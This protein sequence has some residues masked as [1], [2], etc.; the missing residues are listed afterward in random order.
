[1]L[2]GLDL[3]DWKSLRH[4]Y[5]SAEN[6]PNYLRNLLSPEPEKRNAAYEHLYGAVNHQGHISDSTAAVVPFLIELLESEST[7]ERSR[8]LNVLRSFVESCNEHLYM[9]VDFYETGASLGHLRD[10]MDTYNNVAQ[11]LNLFLS[12][13][14]SSDKEVR[15]SAVE[16]LGLLPDQHK[17][18]LEPLWTKLSQEKDDD[19]LASMLSSF[20]MIALQVDVHNY[21]ETLK[22]WIEK[23]KNY[24]VRLR[25]AMALIDL[26][27]R[28]HRVYNWYNNVPNVAIETIVDALVH[29]VMYGLGIMMLEGEFTYYLKRL[30]TE[31][32]ADALK[33]R[34][35]N[36]RVAHFIA[37]EMMDS[38]FEGRNNSHRHAIWRKWDDYELRGDFIIYQF[39]GKYDFPEN[40]RL[41]QP[42]KNLSREQKF[43]LQQ[44]VNCK[45]FW[46][47]K[48]NLFSFFYGLPDDREEL[49]RL[50]EET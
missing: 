49:R 12:L 50:A 19:I 20:G 28:N 31:R 42:N 45:T 3:I 38:A 21:Y 26:L 29:P 22:T 23:H 18:T 25:A 1:M 34:T 30:G 10:E 47:M 9:L 41:Y 8:L 33:V 4:S 27:S 37:R 16:L 39:Q 13:L 14:S 2:E 17:K 7:P 24:Q 48:T 46:R 44:I 11:G 15:K 35:L 36:V 40:N 32:M 5:G 43:T 6:T